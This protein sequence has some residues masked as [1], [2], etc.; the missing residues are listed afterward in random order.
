MSLLTYGYFNMATPL[1]NLDLP[2]V[3]VT[4]GPQWATDVNTALET[5]DSHDHSDGNGAKVKTSG[6]N[7]NADLTFN[8]F[9]ALSINSVELVELGSALSGTSNA[10][11]LNVASGDLYYTNSSGTAV[12]ITSGGTLTPSTSSGDS[13]EVTNVTTDLIISPASTFT[14]LRI[15]TT[16]PRTITLPTASAVSAGRYYILKD[17]SGT[18]NTNN[19]TVSRSSADLIDGEVSVVEDSNYGSKTYVS[20]GVDTWSII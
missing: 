1:M 2:T 4:L 3:S 13:Y 11:R 8:S 10:L 19:I 14:F 15:D 9:S 7:I 20:D 6:L 16:A 18:A 12:Q 17:I 5:I